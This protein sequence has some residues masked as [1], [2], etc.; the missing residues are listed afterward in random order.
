M[1]SNS[2]EAFGHAK[3]IGNN[4]SILVN[5]N[6]E[7]EVHKIFN[8]I[9]AGVNVTMPLDKT[10]WGA[11]FGM[12]TDKFGINWMVKYNYKEQK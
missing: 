6:T 9:S 2:S 8:G 3:F 1:G 4:F 5:A 7:V 10:F 11:L 12:C